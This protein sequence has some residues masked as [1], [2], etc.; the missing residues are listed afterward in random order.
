MMRNTPAALF[1]MLL[2]LAGCSSTSFF[3]SRFNDFSAY[4][5]KYYN[6]QRSLSEGI[7][8]FE[9]RMRVQPIDQDIFLPLFGHGD[10]ASMQRKPFE[11]AVTKSADI[12]RKHPNSKWVDNAIMTI[13]KAWFF[14]N[15]FVGAE[16][17]FNDILELDSP[18]RDEA[19]FWLARTL[20]ASG[21]YEEA[22]THL[23]AVLSAEDLSSRWA[24]YYQLAL[25]ELHVQNENWEEAAVELE[26]GLSTIRDRDLAARA[27]FLEGQVLEQLGRY[28]DAVAAFERV[29]RHKP[30]YEL[31]YAAQFSAVRVLS[32]HVDPDEAMRRLR[33]MERD[34]KNYEHRAQLAYLRGRV[35]T[36]QGRYS[37]ALEEYDELLYDPT[38]GGS[39]VRGRVHY[40]LGTFYRD[41]FSDYPYAAA[42]F[43]TAAGAIQAPGSR[44]Q[45]GRA[46]T[47]P[48][49]PSPGAITDSDDQARI[50][51]SFSEVL[52]RIVLMD[53]LLYLG[54]L[55]DSS[56][57]AVVTELRKRRAE[58]IEEMQREMRQRQSESAF[59]G[60]GVIIE[61]DYGFGAEVLVAGSEG[62]AGF[63]YHK[64]EVRMLQARQDFLSIWGERPLAP[65]WRRIAAIEAAQAEERTEDS[66]EDTREQY[67][68]GR[69]MPTV[70]VSAVPRT[71]EKF[72]AMLTDRA[73]ARYEL[74]NVLF[75]SMNR[76]DSASVWYRMVIEEDKDEL[77]VQRAYYALAEVQRTL[78]D[79][80]A[81]NRLY[82]IIISDYPESDLA[83]QA[84]TRLGRSIP[85][86]ASADSLAMAETAYK[87]SQAQWQQGVSE[88]V[89]NDLFELG[90]EWTTTPVAPRAL[91]A[92]GRAYLEWAAKDS[93][94]VLGTMPVS[95]STTRLEAA[96]F[97]PRMDSTATAEDSLLTLPMLLRYIRSN[98]SNSLQADRANLMLVALQEDQR[99]RRVIAD[100]L[101]A[102]ELAVADSLQRVADSLAL[103][104][105]IPTDSLILTLDS[106]SLAQ[107]DS[108]N[109]VSEVG[110]DSS[111]VGALDSMAVAPEE[112]NVS[113]LQQA[114]IVSSDEVEAA[115]EQDAETEQEAV[116]EPLN[117]EG[118]SSL[119]VTSDPGL[120]N[121]DWSLG[122][123]TIHLISYEDHEMAKAF[124]INF[125]RSLQD[126]QQALDIYGAEVQGGI[127]FRVGLGLF[128][129]V[130]EAESVIQQLSGRIP[131]DARISRIQG[132][133]Q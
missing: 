20:I 128:N 26:A 104:Q 41:V 65:N 71:Q 12:L 119:E 69:V 29:Q 8:G 84:Y 75:L 120:G 99:R 13:G 100:S 55:D 88:E 68:V 96:G 72:D 32:D 127:E 103:Q 78:G 129:T 85:D 106:D 23:Q 17:K 130:R 54:T 7:R 113:D 56:F 57:A 59:R 25:A 31:S 66:D 93:V 40:A 110:A 121:I 132:T 34:D 133:Q 49:K 117:E 1:C 53:S 83:D 67:S 16:E 97:Y 35:L 36:E 74:A 44:Q 15:N 126:V 10:Q 62:E 43:D 94:D 48:P 46:I 80:L 47:I 24:P 102:R 45:P 11:D 60:G 6:A 58:E 116:Q 14:T 21:V 30:F 5:N 61:D 52:D 105:L 122:G 2:F 28:T 19:N 90:L 27:Q 81:A 98:Y 107:V 51:G 73:N 38:A 64:D 4:Y 82:E 115:V 77:V 33:R 18:L 63:L 70:D 131:G 92:A 125:G 3:G 101:A 89:I 76:P 91:Y 123:Y 9:D 87:N 42:H 111:H 114:G 79:T 95:T 50:F 112:G 37:E 118:S 109:M 124:V 86:R 108:L 22:F 39:Q